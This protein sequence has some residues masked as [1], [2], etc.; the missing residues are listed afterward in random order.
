MVSQ[1]SRSHG[2]KT[3]KPILSQ[4]LPSK[5]LKDSLIIG[6]ALKIILRD[7]PAVGGVLAVI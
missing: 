7:I 2:K 6:M 4:F 5:N 3:A 1:L